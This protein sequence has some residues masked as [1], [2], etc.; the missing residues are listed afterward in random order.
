MMN[1]FAEVM[2][3]T[4]AATPTLLIAQ[5]SYAQLAQITDVQLLPIEDGLQLV[6]VTADPTSPQVFQ[7]Q[8]GNTL[9][10]D[11]VGAQLALPAG[12]SYQQENPTP[13]VASISVEQ[14]TEQEV[15]I[16]IT[17]ADETP[18]DAYLE[19]A[20]EALILDIV[21]AG[22]ATAP[23]SEAIEF[24]DTL[25]IIVAADPLPRYRVPT[26][27]AGTRTDTDILDIPQ[28]IQVIPEAVLEDQGTDSLG[29]ALRNASGVSVGRTA[30]G[31]RATTPV[32]RG[33]ETN[34]I[35]R[36]GLRDETLRLG[37]GI[38]NIERI[39]VLKG[40]ASVLFGA[41][42]LG[43]TVNLVTEVP[44]RA[45][46]YE[47]ELTAGNYSVYGMAL[48]FT[49]PLADT[50][51]YRA[52]LAYEN[53]GSFVDFENSEF[54]FFAPTLQV[55][56]T[57]RT[58]LII[59]FEYLYNQVQAS[60]V[61]LPAI[62]AIGIEENT[63]ADRFLAGGAF[64]EADIAQAGSLD[65][66]TNTGEPEISRAESNISRI[67]YRLDHQI[68]DNW[69]VRNEFLGAF[70]NTAQDSFVVP[71][72]FLQQG[73]QL[74]FSR[75]NRI[76]LN[77]PSN[78]EAYTLNTNVVGNFKVVGIDQT[79][80][81]GVEWF[82]E[83]QED[84]LI[85]RQFLPALTPDVEPFNVFEPNYDAR[86]FFPEDNPDFSRA[87]RSDSFTRRRTIGLYGQSQL[88]LSDH[89]II[90]TGGR[91]DFV[92]QFFRD[93]ANL[94][95]PLPIETFDTAFSPRVGIVYKP[96]ESFSI[97]TSYTESFNPTLGQSVSGDVFE[98]ER[99]NQIEVGIKADMLD[100]RLSATLA[101]YRLRRTNVLTQDS[102]NPGFQ[103]QVGEQASDGVELDI[104]G[105][106]VPGWNIIANYAYTDARITKA[107]EFEIGTGLLNVPE[108]AASLWT[109]YEIQEGDF[110]GLGAG[111]GV[112][113]VGD[114]NGDL[115]TP[116][117]IPSYLRTD[118]S[119]FYR[120]DQFRAQLN[121]QNLFDVRYFEGAR[122]QFR[123]TSGAPFTIFGTIG[124]EF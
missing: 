81:L 85:S 9:L 44:L 37:S 117:T 13:S 39:E 97:Y 90:L 80:L 23:D 63:L 58:S 7:S 36:N 66:R 2:I 118:A 17:A 14:A 18:P 62:S 89:L 105:E 77:N 35:L 121:F 67:S 119:I 82:Q 26:A 106:L 45:P 75:L 112:Y 95:N 113:F 88:N 64:S 79:L 55:L 10:I 98:P 86:R 33:F 38:T 70:Q 27:R 120:R 96:I 59:D 6:L 3:V 111:I 99:G 29:E 53:R 116:F 114:R 8:D 74:D 49:G 12:S 83:T 15:R 60:S 101:Y 107:N 103:V 28:G 25:R 21:T 43:G 5:P 19:R 20:A 41:G 54:F 32:I 100:G 115:R 93:D 30:S 61:G 108:H 47:A 84:Q 102:V 4:L 50:T 65:I 72:S 122:D 68:N 46:R 34:N 42:N 124:W 109:S 52:N 91:I 22:A 73:G 94:T 110:T 56:D 24:G 87:V 71:V 57:E 123:V 16:A 76:Y 51:A 31:S 48:D 40:P 92:D 69:H 104:A 1:H 78:R 11:L